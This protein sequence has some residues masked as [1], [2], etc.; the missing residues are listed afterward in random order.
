MITIRNTRPDDFPQIIELTKV[1]YP[2]SG[3]WRHE[4]LAS[5][6][7]IFPEGQFVAIESTSGRVLGFS[8][9]LIIFWD[10]YDMKMSWRDFTDAG[11]FTNHDPRHGKTLYGADVIVDPKMQ[12][13]GIG[14]AL[15]AARRKLVE[16]L[17]LFRI[18]AGSRLQGYHQFANIMSAEEYVFRIVQGELSDPT[19]SFQLHQGFHVLAVVKG[20]LHHDPKSLGHAAVIEWVNERI[21]K[22]EDYAKRGDWMLKR[23]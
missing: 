23:L 16:Q 22:P 19:L 18:R 7:K 2:K 5:H 17:Q 8:S 6:L 3:G 4:Q 10:D 9:S 20:Y 13:H 14:K 21:A 1:E 12:G 15:Y 11:F